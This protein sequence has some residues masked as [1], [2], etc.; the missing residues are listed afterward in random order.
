MEWVSELKGLNLELRAQIHPQLYP[1]IQRQLEEIFLVFQ[2][3]LEGIYSASIKLMKKISYLFTSARTD[4]VLM[5]ISIL[6]RN[7]YKLK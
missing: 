3:Q 1:T 5:C 4:V 7:R 2:R 6:V